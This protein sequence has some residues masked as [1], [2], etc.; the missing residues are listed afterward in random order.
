MELEKGI[1]KKRIKSAVKFKG[2]DHNPESFN[3]IKP[4]SLITVK[5]GWDDININNEYTFCI[6]YIVLDQSNSSV[7][8]TVN[9]SHNN[10]ENRFKVYLENELKK[11]NGKIWRWDDN[12][13]LILF[14]YDGERCDAVLACFKLMRDRIFVSIEQCNSSI[15]LSYT[16]I[17]HLGNLKYQQRG[18]TGTTISESINFIYHASET[19][20]KKGIFYITDSLYDKIPAGYRDLFV[21]AGIFEGIEMKRMKRVLYNN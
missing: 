2:H 17:L 18:K 10:L 1:D 20:T 6:M 7:K 4:D 19:F 13:G 3:T 16:I 21:P 9:G 8:K 15:L 5:G 11:I 14:P 12:Q